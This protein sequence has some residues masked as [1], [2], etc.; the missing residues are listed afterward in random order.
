ME[1]AVCRVMSVKP[2]VFIP[3]HW[4]GRAEV[5]K[6]YSRKGRTKYTEVLA[7]TRPR[8]RAELTFGDQ[9][10]HIHI[11]APLPEAENEMKIDAFS[12]NDPFADT[13]LPVRL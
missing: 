4:Q 6:S 9:E 2:R 8:E 12:G 11:S 1:F 5:A 7:L 10:L 13:D 3:M